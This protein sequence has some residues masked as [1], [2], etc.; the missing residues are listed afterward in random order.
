VSIELIFRLL[1]KP[2][3]E[4]DYNYYYEKN[5]PLIFAVSA[6]TGGEVTTMEDDPARSPPQERETDGN[7]GVF[8]EPS[9]K[10][11]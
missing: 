6:I 10:F 2:R 3:S 1:F 4:I 11:G 8:V 7:V 9:A 5:G